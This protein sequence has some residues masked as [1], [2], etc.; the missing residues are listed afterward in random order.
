MLG[1][2]VLPPSDAGETLGTAGS[3]S[4]DG[5][6]S[7]A[8]SDSSTTN[9]SATSS[10]PTESTDSTDSG[11]GE[12]EECMPGVI[13]AGCL[14]KLDIVIVVDNSAG[15]ADAQR[16]LGR[17]MPRL[18]S[19]LTELIDTSGDPVELDV[20]VMITT[21]DM[22]SALC[23]PF[24]PAGY[25]P[26]LGSP[27]A[28]SCTD[29]LDDFTSLDGTVVV[30]EAC[31]AVCP[32]GIAPTENF[33]AFG[34]SG[35]NVPNVPEVDIDGDGLL[36][37]PVAQALACLVPQGIVGC[38]YESPLETMI[39]AINDQAPW[40]SG[41]QPS[42]RNDAALAIM[43]VSNEP[44]CSLA[45]QAV[46]LDPAYQNIS[47]DLGMPAPSSAICWNAGVECTPGNE[48]GFYDSCGSIQTFG[49]HPVS[50]YT[51]YLDYLRD[52]L[53]KD[54]F[55]MEV[56]GV[57]P[58]VAHDP[59]PPFSPVS[60]GVHD[61]LYRD[62]VGLPYPNGDIDP[63]E[64]A[65]GIR[66]E[67]KQFEFGIGPGCNLQD[68]N[69][70]FQQATPPVRMLEVCDSL[71]FGDP[72]FGTR[73]CVE[74]VCDHDLSSSYRCLSGMLSPQGNPLGPLPGD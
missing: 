63:A 13:Q 49:M 61:L 2:C 15:M 40:N 5:A 9:S 47:P 32:A 24:H 12:P 46:L 43:L 65:E 36:D 73:C 22:D 55:M 17:S 51:Q 50:R 37:P 68:E 72:E 60:G 58:V 54:V 52:A 25:T 41:P 10:N 4:D 26:S 3:T 57:P 42:V 35:T 31:T 45:N 34:P 66:G 19:D 74:S 11:S 38:G 28:T 71:N 69:G 53:G 33:V 56:V 29:R 20:Q 14:N 67:D 18:V 70:A 27:I 23:K 59:N 64:W 8:G 30:P 21:T 48:A 7:P 16:E 44:D 6:T 62:W 1:G 39:Q